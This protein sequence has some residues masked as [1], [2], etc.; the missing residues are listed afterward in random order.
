M[1]RARPLGRG[2]FQARTSAA[3]A[4]PSLTPASTRRGSRPSLKNANGGHVAHGRKV[5]TS[6]AQVANTIML[7]TRSTKFE[8]CAQ[9]TGG[10]T[11]FCTDLE[12]AKIDG[13]PISERGRKAVDSNAVFIDG[14]F[15]P[16]HP[17]SSSRGAIHCVNSF[18][19]PLMPNVRSCTTGHGNENHPLTRLADAQE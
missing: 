2:S 15:I 1:E 13:R 8:D 18:S 10:V 7:L 17:G 3:S 14:L 5:R 16:E 4:S 6:T 9:P 11:I 12:R 19:P